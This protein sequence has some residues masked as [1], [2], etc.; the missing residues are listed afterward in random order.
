MIEIVNSKGMLMY[1]LLLTKA[2]QG[3]TIPTATWAN[4]VYF[5]RYQVGDKTLQ[6]GKIEVI[7]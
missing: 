2:N 7:K 5:Y 4:G 1:T 6:S 3:A